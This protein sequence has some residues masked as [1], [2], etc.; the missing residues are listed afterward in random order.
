MISST[1]YPPVRGISSPQMTGTAGLVLAG[2]LPLVPTSTVIPMYLLGGIQL[3]SLGLI[4][5]YLAKVYEAI[6]GHWGQG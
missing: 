1:G 4:G 5:E 2:L 3:L 6:T